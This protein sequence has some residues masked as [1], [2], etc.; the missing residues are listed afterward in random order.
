M[1]D[2]AAPPFEF[3][4]LSADFAADPHASYTRMRDLRRPYYYAPEDTWMLTR[5]A[6]VRALA[7]DDTMLRSVEGLV[8]P[9][10][11]RAL[12]IKG[13][14]HDMPYHERYV[15]QNML[16]IEGEKHDRQRKLVFRDFTPALVERQRP[17]IQSLVDRLL[18]PLIEAG[19]FDF[20]NDFAAHVPGH[21]IGHILG[22]PEADSP[23]LRRW[24]E[25]VVRYY[26][27]GR[28]AVQKQ[29]AETAVREFHAYLS[30]M[31]AQRHKRPTDDLMSRLVEHEKAGR[32]DADETISLAMLIL[33]AGHGSTIDVLGSGLHSLLRFPDQHQRLR[34]DPGLMRSAVHEMFRFESPLPY[35]H[36]FSTTEAVVAGQSFPRGTRFGLLYGAANRDP[37]QFERAHQFDVGRQPVRHIAFGGGAHFCLGNHLARL[38]ME[39]IFTA[40]NQRLRQIA[41]VEQPIY[42][43]GLSVRG[44]Q[45]LE[46]E[47]QAV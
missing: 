33:M 41:L 34:S 26:N 39:I 31:I 11:Q 24:S 4:P 45:A 28:T 10:E 46:I 42:K 30:D 8:S 29:Q 12:Q 5:Y 36:R 14:M 9:E 16:D 40:L 19:R 15:Q 32:T 6:D 47:T 2:N 35:F 13:G 18:G 25:H 1:P 20:V 22:V 21:V 43:P 37:E 7:L 38:D 23:Q 17:Y 3:D 44:P 27:V